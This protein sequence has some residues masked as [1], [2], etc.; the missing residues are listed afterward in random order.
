MLGF[1]RRRRRPK[2][3][4]R[5]FPAA[6]RLILEERLGYY[7]CLPPEDRRELEGHVQVFLAEKRFEGC[8]GLEI[9]D[10]IRV[11]IAAQACRLLLHRDTDYYP[12]LTTILVSPSSYV[13]QQK[14]IGPAGVVTEGAT[15]RLG[16][17][18][19]AA[20][21]GGP[22]VLSWQDVRA[23]AADIHDGRNVV[24][25]E[26]AHQLDGESGSVEGAPALEAR[27]MYLAWARV[28][29][30]EFERLAADLRERRPTVLDA[31][32][33]TSPAEFF[34]VLTEAFFE[35]PGELRARHPELYEQLRLFYRQD[36]AS[37]RCPA[38]AE[39]EA[40]GGILRG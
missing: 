32:G 5:P 30:G 16:E 8:A 15:V 31:Y 17:S 26:F 3:R 20:G 11:T 2:V 34:A 18:W 28:L 35:K 27:S 40:A 24:F 33:A 13:A 6:W 25:H 7:C 10:E 36:P 9:T 14:S 29:G 4:A 12:G 23:G 19:H 38:G 21:V 1:F 37:L 39:S 22:V